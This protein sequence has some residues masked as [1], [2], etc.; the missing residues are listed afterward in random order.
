MSFKVNNLSIMVDNRNLVDSLSFEVKEGE[1]LLL[2]GKSGSG[3]TTILSSLVGKIGESTTVDEIDYFGRD[4]SNDVFVD[5][6]SY[7]PQNYPLFDEAK[8]SEN[9]EI[10]F[11]NSR[12]YYSVCYENFDTYELENEGDFLKSAKKLIKK[13]KLKFNKE[14][15]DNQID[16]IFKK[17]DL[18]YDE[19]KNKKP[20]QLS[21]GQ[22]QRLSIACALLK[23]P[24]LILM[25]EPFANLDNKTS[26]MIMEFILDLKSEGISFIISSHDIDV[27][28]GHED[29][30]ILI[31]GGGNW[32]ESNISNLKEDRDNEWVVSYFTPNYNLIDDSYYLYSEVEVSK[33][34]TGDLYKVIGCKKWKESFKLIVTSKGKEI[35]LFSNEELSLGSD[36]YIKYDKKK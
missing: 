22:R 16:F 15:K 11:K 3:K 7:I 36:I 30:G 14:N 2:A 23:K 17:M 27:I 10:T 8:V 24:K 25:D 33:D 31:S 12:N 28:E 6:I 32:K 5:V 29:K 26:E 13:N 21:G 18:S 20:S 19:I 9:V 1:L 34:K 4:F 35:S